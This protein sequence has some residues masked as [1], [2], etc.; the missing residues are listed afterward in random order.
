MIRTMSGYTAKSVDEL[1]GRAFAAYNG[2]RN[3]AE[4]GALA[5]A[6]IAVGALGARATLLAAGLG[7]ALIG[8]VALLLLTTSA[9][10]IRGRTLHARVQG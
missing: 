9:S 4:L 1:R 6:G 10:T 5:L 2:A 8:L 3:G 7:P